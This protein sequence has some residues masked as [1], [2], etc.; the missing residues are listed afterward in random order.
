MI[1]VNRAANACKLVIRREQHRRPGVMAI[2]I[3][4]QLPDRRSVREIR[5][6]SAREKGSR[7]Q[8]S[9]W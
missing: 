2:E 4:H 8:K 9:L 5:S 6:R 3:I 1:F 7:R